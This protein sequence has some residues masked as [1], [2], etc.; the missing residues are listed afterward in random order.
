VSFWGNVKELREVM[1]MADDGRLTSIPLEF[2]PLERI[3][4]VYQRLKNG[5]VEG[6]AVITP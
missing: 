5:Q 4:D 2:E 3:N 1:E 6:R